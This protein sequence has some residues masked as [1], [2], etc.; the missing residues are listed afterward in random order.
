MKIHTGSAAFVGDRK[1]VQHRRRRSRQSPLRQKPYTPTPA[2]RS[3]GLWLSTTDDLATTLSAVTPT[4][5]PPQVPVTVPVPVANF[6]TSSTFEP[7]VFEPILNVPALVTFVGITTVFSALIVRTNQVEDAVQNRKK[8]QEEVRALKAR[9]VGEGTVSP[10]EL[11]DTLERYEQAVRTEESLRNLVPGV[12]RI[13]PPSASDKREE[14][15]RAIARQYLGRDFDIGVPKRDTTTMT[16]GGEGGGLPGA[17][18]GVL[19]LV[20]LSQVGLLA[21]FNFGADP[22]TGNGSA[23]L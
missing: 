18:I 3:A 15:A 4:P 16:E 21:F 5:M 23:L 11:R 8:R 10:K 14:E 17:A 19:V 2:E 13:V 6:D 22:V 1:S 20:A 7:V 12:V 9:E